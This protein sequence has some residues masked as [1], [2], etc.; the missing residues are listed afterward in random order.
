VDEVAANGDITKGRV[1]N[2]TVTDWLIIDDIG[3]TR[4]A[5]V[6]PNNAGTP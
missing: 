4:P 2:F 1:W 5:P 6:D 3:L